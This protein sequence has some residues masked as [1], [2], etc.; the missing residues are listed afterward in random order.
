[1]SL[2]T[3][4]LEAADGA[5][6]VTQ[7]LR[8]ALGSCQ[9]PPD[10]FD[11][12]P[13]GRSYEQLNRDSLRDRGPQFLLQVGDQVYLDASGGLFKP[14]LQ[15]SAD[16]RTG[17]LKRRG[18]RE[19]RQF[20][21]RSLQLEPLRRTLARMPVY[22]LLDDHEVWNDWRGLDDRDHPC[23]DVAAAL[24]NYETYQH[25]LVAGCQRLLEGPRNGYSYRIAPGGLDFFVLDT[26][27]RRS[28]SHIAPPA[29]LRRL[30]AQL[31]RV[32]GPKFIAM[33]TPLLP[34]EARPDGWRGDGWA[35]FPDSA[36]LLVQAIRDHDIR[37]VV[38]LSGDS[39]LSSVTRFR[40][41]GAR[42]G[43]NEI[44]SVVSSG[45][46]APWPFSN[47]RPDAV[48]LAGPCTVGGVAGELVVDA[49]ATANGFAELCWQ[50]TSPAPC[51]HLGVQL[52]DGEGAV[53]ARCE[54]DLA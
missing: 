21:E 53:V 36:A 28:P 41:T 23:V 48:A 46:Y 5:P 18:E 19:I 8:F 26:R 17:G 38:L 31:R 52:K 40:F 49:L 54:L 47:M 12:E 24:R 6:L 25:V 14:V 16:E 42:G 45:F 2:A 30:I 15:A 34:P 44:V 3:Q 7:E 11:R 22:P 4:R 39:H 10:L 35:A 9:T 32:Q 37:G 51:G 20:Y 13:A 43:D 50:R 27:S 33:S 29:L 1:M